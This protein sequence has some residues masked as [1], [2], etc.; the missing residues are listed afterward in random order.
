MKFKEDGNSFLLGVP[1][2]LSSMEVKLL[3]YMAFEL[4]WPIYIIRII[5]KRVSFP[6]IS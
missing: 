6:D 4:S 1:I 3:P 5:Q 2:A